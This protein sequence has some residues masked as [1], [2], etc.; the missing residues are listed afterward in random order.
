[1]EKMDK[2]DVW[3]VVPKDKQRTLTGKWVF[4]RKIDGATGK[5]AAHK[6]RFVVRGFQQIAG[7]DFVSS[8]HLSPIN[9][10]YEFSCQLSTTWTGSVTRWT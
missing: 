9:R 8:L 1:M 10:H 3:E 4:T 6:A 2:Y 5:A 7:R